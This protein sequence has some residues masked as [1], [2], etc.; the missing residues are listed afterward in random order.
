MNYLKIFSPATVANVSCGFDA[1]GLAVDGIGDEMTFTK[2]SDKKVVISQITGANL[3]YETHLN[4]AGAVA[5]KMLQDVN[6]DFGLV[7]TLHK[8]FMPGSGLGS[9]AASAAG[10]A[11]GV[12]QFLN[13][14]FSKTELTKYAMY[15]EE[16]ACGT[17]IAD[18]VAAAIFGGFILVRSVNPLEIIDLPVPDDLYIALIHP[19]VTVKT[20][21]ARE[22]LPDEIP[23]AKAVKQWANVGGLV[24]G[25][26][27]KEYTLIAN[28]LQDFIVEP[29]RKHL[30]PHF[31]EIKHNAI[32]AG[33]LGAGISGSGP[34]IFAL[35]KGKQT[36]KQVANSMN[37]TYKNKGII[38]NVYHSKINT[39]GVKVISD[40]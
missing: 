29:A 6:A 33:A 8:G 27:Q 13:R 21:E 30:I 24:S 34:T 5:Q 1:L 2:T 25:L 36:A 26:Y 17:P 38:Y 9:S 19:Q 3:P 7:I 39:E 4:A 37:D 16:V 35:C 14:Q 20:Q 11:F 18:N 31:D 23:L 15:G 28:S 22:V 10:A 32:K 40:Q 12:N